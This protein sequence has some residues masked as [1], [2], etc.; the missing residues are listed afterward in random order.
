MYS[1]LSLGDPFFPMSS[2]LC[3]LIELTTSPGVSPRSTLGGGG[4][5]TEGGG[6]LPGLGGT[7]LEVVVWAEG[8]TGGTE[9]GGGLCGWNGAG[10]G[11][12]ALAGLISFPSIG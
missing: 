11:G 4:G 2:L 12:A 3:S 10:L 5:G 8:N 1:Y 7:P 6:F 9:E